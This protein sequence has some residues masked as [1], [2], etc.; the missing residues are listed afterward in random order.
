MSP[1]MCWFLDVGNDG[2]LPKLNWPA[3][4]SA[5]WTWS[6]MKCSEDQEAK[7]PSDSKTTSNATN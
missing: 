1:D 6:G 4:C 2:T 5:K 3:S 7:Q